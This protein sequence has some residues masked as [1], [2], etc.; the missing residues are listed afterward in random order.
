MLL[1][2]YLVAQRLV[3]TESKKRLCGCRVLVILIAYKAKRYTE[4][5]GLRNRNINF[6]LLFLNQKVNVALTVIPIVCVLEA[7]TQDSM[8]IRDNDRYRKH[9]LLIPRLYLTDSVFFTFDV[10]VYEMSISKRVR[11]K[12]RSFLLHLPEPQRRVEKNKHSSIRFL[13]KLGKR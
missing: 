1:C 11:R 7:T 4:L 6:H 8:G 5:P 9:L 10:K 13:R 3:H 12:E 2:A